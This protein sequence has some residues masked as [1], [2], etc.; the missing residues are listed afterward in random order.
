MTKYLIRDHFVRE[1]VIEA[2]S[3]E[4]AE[5]K[6]LEMDETDKKCIEVEPGP[7]DELEVLVSDE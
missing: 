2:E 7:V 5:N 6:Y 4:D 1:F 3:H